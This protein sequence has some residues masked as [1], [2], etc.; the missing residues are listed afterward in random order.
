MKVNPPAMKKALHDGFLNATDLADYLVKHGVP[1]R[2]AHA[3]VGKAVL[4]CESRG[5]AIEDLPLDELKKLSPVIDKDVYSQ[6]DYENTI[7][8]GNKKEML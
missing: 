6:L 2:D 8:L 1:F 4:L 3:I 7:R 5:C